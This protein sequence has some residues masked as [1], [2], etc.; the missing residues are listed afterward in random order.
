MDSDRSG[1]LCDAEEE[2]GSVNQY[3]DYEYCKPYSGEYIGFG[4]EEK[5]ESDWGL[6]IVSIF[7]M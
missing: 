5:A 6:V 2:N 1:I 4:T 3:H 7:D